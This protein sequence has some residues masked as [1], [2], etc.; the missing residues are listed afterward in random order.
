[1]PIDSDVAQQVLAQIDRAELARLACDL[2]DIPSPTGQER[3]SPTTSSTG[4]RGT[5]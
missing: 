4:T 5:A 1:M 2:V 3:R